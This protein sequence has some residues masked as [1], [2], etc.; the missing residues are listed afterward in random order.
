MMWRKHSRT[1]DYEIFPQ[2]LEDFDADTKRALQC[3]MDYETEAWSMVCD[4]SLVFMLEDTSSFC[5]KLILKNAQI[6]PDQD[7]EHLLTETKWTLSK[8]QDGYLLKSEETQVTLAFSDARGEIEVYSC[9]ESQFYGTTPWLRLTSLANGIIEKKILSDAYLNDRER[10]LMPLLEELE[11]ID[12]VYSGQSCKCSF[13]ELKQL[14]GQ[15]ECK[16]LAGYLEQLSQIGAGKRD[17]SK[18]RKIAG[19]IKTIFD[20]KSAEPIWR[21]VYDRI[22]DSQQGY[23]RKVEARIPKELRDQV[24]TQIEQVMWESGYQGTYPDFVKTGSMKGIR[25]TESYWRTYFVGMEKNV[26][27]RVHCE[28]FYDEFQGA[29]GVRLISGTAFLKKGENEKDIIGCLFDAKGRRISFDFEYS[30]PI[31]KEDQ[32][33]ISD[34]LIL[35]VKAAIKHAELR[36]L[37]KA[38]RKVLSNRITKISG[39]FWFIFLA[40]GGMFTL[41]F[42]PG[43]LLM[44][45]L[46]AVLSGEIGKISEIVRDFP[47]LQLC[48]FAWIGVGGGMSLLTILA[49]RKI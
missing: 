6:Y 34:E 24:T 47:W 38:E 43:M 23:L 10:R 39:L 33:T 8:N 7:I 19:R 31:D 36:K 12:L 48:V 46:I 11:A 25:L 42:V 13:G 37:T 16:Q 29:F 5:R 18:A 21:G 1:E 20:E 49:L 35:C 41:L 4:D 28:E 26:Q 3:F 44:A 40:I 17:L 15:Y 9:L 2:E 22:R 30:S 27:Y 32:N 14:C 45:I